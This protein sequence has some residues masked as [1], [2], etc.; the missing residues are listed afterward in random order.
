VNAGHP[1][2]CVLR[3]F[4]RLTGCP[5]LL[6]TSFNLRDEPIVCTPDEALACFFRSELDVLV[7]ETSMIE[8]TAVPP[9]L[10]EA[11][12]CAHVPRLPAIAEHVYVGS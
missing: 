5:A 2:A 1:L 9:S 6:N 8:R 12:R 3:A 10:V 11:V 7:L 4:D